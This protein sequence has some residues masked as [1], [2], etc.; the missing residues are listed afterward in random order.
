MPYFYDFFL[1]DWDGD[2]NN[3]NKANNNTKP[4]NDDFNWDEPTSGTANTQN[5]QTQSNNLTNLYNQPANNNAAPFGW[6]DS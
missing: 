2:N 3:T 4:S 1:G 6:G 5:N